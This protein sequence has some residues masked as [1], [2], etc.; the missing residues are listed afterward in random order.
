LPLKTENL[1]SKIKITGLLKQAES[2]AYIFVSVARYYSTVAVI[3]G[4][5]CIFY[6]L[7][8]DRNMSN[9]TQERT[10]QKRNAVILTNPE[11]VIQD[12]IFD[13]DVVDEIKKLFRQK[14][15]KDWRKFYTY[16]AQVLLQKGL[17]NWAD[18]EGCIAHCLYDIT[19][20]C[21]IHQWVYYSQSPDA[22]SCREAIINWLVADCG[23]AHFD[24]VIEEY[25]AE[26][27][28]RAK[29]QVHIGRTIQMA[30]AVTQEAQLDE[31]EEQQ[32][33][34]DLVEQLVDAIA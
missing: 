3:D 15:D 12:V 18:R 31:A 26:V 13:K 10:G 2:A 19:G 29:A 24:R 11:G 33:E 22:D 16:R 25:E 9:K 20:E 14:R 17:L 23:S 7:W 21:K 34:K 6:P 30:H 8:K 1:S 5:Q 32:E 27:L 4:A 28:A